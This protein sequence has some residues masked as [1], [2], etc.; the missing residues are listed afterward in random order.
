M[1]GNNLYLTNQDEFLMNHFFIVA[2]SLN[3]LWWCIHQIS[4]VF[5]KSFQ[6]SLIKK[7]FNWKWYIIQTLCLKKESFLQLYFEKIWIKQF[8]SLNNESFLQLYLETSLMICVPFFG[9]RLLSNKKLSFSQCY[10]LLFG[11]EFHL[12]LGFLWNLFWWFI[13]I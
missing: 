1:N 10:Q 4:D 5:T 11:V 3:A 7:A 9:C 8:V 12:I 13:V 6:T 2:S